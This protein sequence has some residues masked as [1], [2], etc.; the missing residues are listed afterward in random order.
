MNGVQVFLDFV[1]NSYQLFSFICYTGGV[2]G[3][4]PKEKDVYILRRWNAKVSEQLCTQQN[5]SGVIR[6]LSERQ[7]PLRVVYIIIV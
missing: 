2:T 1:Q 7:E 4:S 5:Y 6:T 3:L